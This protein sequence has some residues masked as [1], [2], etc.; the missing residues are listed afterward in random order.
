MLKVL[1]SSAASDRLSAAAQFLSGFPHS[2]EVLVIGGTRATADDF[3]RHYA[4]LEGATFGIH[5]FSL[6]QLAARISA[7]RLAANG[8]APCSALGMEATVARAV[9]EAHGNGSLQYFSPVALLPGF[10][11]AVRA[12]ASE[13]RAAGI[14]AVDLEHLPPPGPDVSSLLAA[15]EGQ[16]TAAHL[17]D[18]ASLMRTAAS[19]LRGKE[20]SLANAPVLLLDIPIHSKA[21]FEFVEALVSTAVPRQ[22][23]RR[24]NVTAAQLVGRSFGE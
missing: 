12:T 19:V 16:L 4:R 20:A 22:N 6:V 15:I 24:N 23:H 18:M 5:R 8:R 11:K 21:E 2:A 13:L 14:A 17:V 3:V 10:A 9:H 1:I 7:L